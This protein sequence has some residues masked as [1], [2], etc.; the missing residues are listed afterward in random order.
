M[1]GPMNAKFHEE[2]PSGKR[3]VVPCVCKIVRKAA[4]NFVMS[5]RPFII[6]L[7][8]SDDDDDDDNNRIITK[9]CT[10]QRTNPDPPFIYQP[11]TNRTHRGIA[12]CSRQEH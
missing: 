12:F 11:G 8:T 5:V 2:S 7:Y 1:H 9:C 3:R 4:I 10:V 6:Y